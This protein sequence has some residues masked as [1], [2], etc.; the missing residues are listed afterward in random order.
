MSLRAVAVLSARLRSLTRTG[1]RIPLQ[2]NNPVSHQGIALAM[3]QIR[4]IDAPLG[5]TDAAV[6][7]G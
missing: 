6:R 4:E 2:Q 7:R 1:F 5:A 3:P